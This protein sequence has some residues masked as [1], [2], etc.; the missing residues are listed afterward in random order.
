MRGGR[1]SLVVCGA[2]FE[3]TSIIVG[4]HVLKD[5]VHLEGGQTTMMSNEVNMDSPSSIP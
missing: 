2:G 4:R 5:G 1:S 3:D